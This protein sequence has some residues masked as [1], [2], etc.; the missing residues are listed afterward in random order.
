MPIA[1][2]DT[3]TL[4][5]A[6]IFA[7]APTRA[8]VVSIRLVRSNSFRA[9]VQRPPA[10]EAP[11][12]F[13]TASAPTPAPPNSPVEGFHA[14][15][16]PCLAP[17][18]TVLDGRIS[19]HTVCPSRANSLSSAVPT[20]PV[21]PVTRTFISS[22]ALGHQKGIAH[23]LE[24]Y[25]TPAERSSY[26]RVQNILPHGKFQTPCPFAERQT[27]RAMASASYSHDGSATPPPGSRCKR[28]PAG[29]RP[30]LQFL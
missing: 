30:A 8:R 20:S 9:F 29:L 14:T 25:E 21:E 17:P 18:T 10:I 28:K 16:N 5:R 24:R 26:R 3:S 13:T 22:S 15:S 4:G 23:L 6:F 2:A 11:A 19:R 7:S 27:H 12:R 1:E